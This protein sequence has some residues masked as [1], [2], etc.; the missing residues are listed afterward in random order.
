MIIGFYQNF[1]K[2]PKGNKKVKTNLN[3]EQNYICIYM[4]KHLYS[5]YIKKPCNSII[6]QKSP[7][8]CGQKI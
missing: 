7:L 8:N 2:F 5:E 4:T 1:K 6:R 3:I